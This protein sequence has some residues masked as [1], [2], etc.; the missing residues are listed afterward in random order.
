MQDA[1]VLQGDDVAVLAKHNPAIGI[2]RRITLGILCLRLGL[3]KGPSMLFRQKQVCHCAKGGGI[4]WE[5]YKTEKTRWFL[6]KT[7]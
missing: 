2:V 3:A 7:I 4:A 6:G 1:L 5:K